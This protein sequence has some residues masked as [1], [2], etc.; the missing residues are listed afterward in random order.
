[1]RE[2]D[3]TRAL[4]D[5]RSLS[6][7]RLVGSPG[8]PRARENVVQRLADAGIAAEQKPF[9]FFPALPFGILLNIV[10][11]SVI[12]LLIYR[13]LLS[14]QPRTGA[15]LGLALPLIARALWGAYRRAA[16]QKL[17]DHAADYPWHTRF[18]RRPHV[19]LDSANI[20]VD[21]PFVGEIKQRLVLL[22]HTD[23]KSQNM[24]IVTR[25]TSS[26]LL[27]LG[28]FVLPIATSLGLLWPG[29]V[30]GSL[31]AVWWTLWIL[32]LLGAL[33][34]TT[35]E[36]RDESCGAIDNAGSCGVL[37]ETARAVAADPPRGV[38]VRVVFTGAEELGLA[39]G[40]AYAREAQAD[41]DW[42]DAIHL[43]FEGAGSGRKLWYTSETGPTG[44]YAGAGARAT[45]LALQGIRRAGLSARRLGKLI[46]GE[47]DHIPLVEAGLSAVT[48]MF[49]GGHT[50]AVHTRDDQAQLL[51]ADA[52]AA[53]GAIALGAV[54]ALEERG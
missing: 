8:E 3:S 28:V 11:L 29:W 53:A 49:S 17:E 21:L 54:A 35:L 51:Q 12:L 10:R 2:F 47:A 33:V 7:P 15:L 48:L 26:I 37:L 23:S 27:A 1:M 36:V 32:A 45:D 31:A 41:P 18:I 30:T 52:M 16:A 43:N 40:Y 19:A 25:A 9:R 39:G 6:F 4:A 5:A 44:S 13:F 38:A 46:G 34:L 14:W 22:A 42:R 24:S 20:V 50:I